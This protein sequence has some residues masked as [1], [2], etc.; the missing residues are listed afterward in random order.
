MLQA[1][2]QLFARHGYAGTSLRAVMADAG[3]DT[4]AIHYHFKNKLGLLKA[5]FE[6]RV[7]RVNEQREALLSG[8]E[9]RAQAP[10]IEE[11]LQAFIAPALHTAY[12]PSEAAFNRVT[13]LCS[14]D[15][16][17]EVREVVFQAY[18]P[19]AQ[20]F[21]RLLRQAAPHLSDT[22]FQWRLEC[23]YGAMMYIRSDNGRVSSLLNDAHR[24]EP[25]EQ[26]IAQL[27]AFTAAGFKAG[28]DETAPRRQ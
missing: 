23:M 9:Q 5:L 14:V 7:S 12:S 2:E 27:V 15:P 1:A 3:V 24:K 10:A 11:V 28:A 18:D 16:L 19:V 8:L 22:A 21:A 6:E 25:V 17:Q 26:V 13:A 20:R 4:G